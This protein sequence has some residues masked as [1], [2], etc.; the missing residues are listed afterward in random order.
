MMAR[1]KISTAK[2]TYGPE[3]GDVVTHSDAKK[4]VVV[5]LESGHSCI[6]IPVQGS[7]T[8]SYRNWSNI[9][10]MYAKK[11]M[12]LASTFVSLPAHTLTCTGS[13]FK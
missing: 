6:G 5:G 1:I 4:S 12:D 11:K 3:I 7:P 10:A 8:E 13:V 2:T 9:V